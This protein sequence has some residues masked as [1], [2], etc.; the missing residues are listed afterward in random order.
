MSFTRQRDNDF[1]NSTCGS[2]EFEKQTNYEG[3]HHKKNASTPHCFVD[4]RAHES[5]EDN[6]CSDCAGSVEAL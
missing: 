5:Y 3:S 4:A 2:H 6:I 1:D